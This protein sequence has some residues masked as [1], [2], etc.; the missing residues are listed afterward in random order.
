MNWNYYEYFGQCNMEYCVIQDIFIVVICIICLCD[1]FMER[2]W[3][4]VE[5]LFQC[6]NESGIGCY[7]WNVL[8]LI[9]FIF[10]GLLGGVFGVL[11]NIV[12]LFLIKYRMKYV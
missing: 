1:Y 6:V 7:F 12:N 5:I 4:K 10:M 3:L 2:R 11:F 9:V 8:D